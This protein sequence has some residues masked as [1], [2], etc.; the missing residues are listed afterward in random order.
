MFYIEYLLGD[1]QKPPST[2]TGKLNP[3]G[4]MS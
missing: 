3:Q 1:F 4:T 2:K